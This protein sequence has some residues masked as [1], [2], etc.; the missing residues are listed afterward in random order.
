MIETIQIQFKIYT[1][2]TKQSVEVFVQ[3]NEKSPWS[4]FEIKLQIAS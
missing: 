4:N 1:S 3:F 2:K